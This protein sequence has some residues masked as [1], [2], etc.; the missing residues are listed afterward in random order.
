[1][2]LLLS[3]CGGSVQDTIAKAQD[4]GLTPA[5]RCSAIRDLASE[6]A[7]GV[8]PLGALAADPDPEVATCARESIADVDDPAAAK[9]LEGLLASTDAGV[10]VSA[11][12][13]LGKI[14]KPTSTPSLASLL[15]SPDRRVVLAAVEALGRIGD[16]RAVPALNKVALRR[17]STRAE[18]RASRKARQAAVVALGDIGDAAARSTLVRVLSTDPVSSRA[19]GTALARIYEPDVTPLLPLLQKRGNIALAYALVD[20]GQKGTEG[21]LV[22]ALHRYG[23]LDLAE[24]YLNCGND[25]LESA[26]VTWAGNHGYTV[27]TQPGVGGG[28]WGS[29]P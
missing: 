24:Y 5:Q 18:E 22:T 6:G 15:T 16:P 26:A 29:G 23:D 25:R 7:R 8:A 12:D 9:A 2:L 27:F 10:L 20:V 14:G 17:G 3:A 21:A 4:S 1:M 28:Q 19:A 13:A 11:A